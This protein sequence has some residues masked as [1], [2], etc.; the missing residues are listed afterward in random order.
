MVQHKQL[1]M[2]DRYVVNV[3]GTYRQSRRH[4]IESH[5]EKYDPGIFSLYKSNSQSSNKLPTEQGADKRGKL[6]NRWHFKVGIPLAIISII[7]S[8]TYMWRFFHPKPKEPVHVAG[9]AQAAPAPAKPAAPPVSSVWRVVGVFDSGGVFTFV[10]QDA[11]NRVRFLVDP[12][13]F[14]VYGSDYELKL[15]DGDFVTSWSGAVPGA[16]PSRGFK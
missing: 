10:L 7:S 12:P 9:A 1:G 4:L 13:D 11:Q 14:K 16:A 3:Y 2:P 15:P 5:Q 6:W 8:V